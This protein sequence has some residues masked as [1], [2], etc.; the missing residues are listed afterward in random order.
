MMYH[1][2]KHV[3]EPS[4]ACTWVNPEFEVVGECL[5]RIPEIEPEGVTTISENMDH[6]VNA[7]GPKATSIPEFIARWAYTNVK[8]DS[9]F[10][11]IEIRDLRQR[12]NM[13]ALDSRDLE[14]LAFPPTAF[15][16]NC[17]LGGA[18]LGL[19]RGGLAVTVGMDSTE[20]LA[21]VW[22]VWKY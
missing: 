7:N 3:G 5:V 9:N 14:N 4:D 13:V 19:R 8:T 11:G 1:D 15:D 16:L 12:S 18:S 20:A 6:P 21:D 17:G 2:W 10:E 22:K